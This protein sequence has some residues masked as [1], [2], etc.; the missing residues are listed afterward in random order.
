ME[1]E[2]NFIEFVVEDDVANSKS[3]KIIK[4]VGMEN[5]FVYEDFYTFLPL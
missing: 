5:Q 2:I 1:N 3:E 4:R